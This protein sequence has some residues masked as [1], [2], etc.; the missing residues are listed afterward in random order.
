MVLLLFS[1]VWDMR[2]Q[3]CIQ[4]L[5]DR[6][7]YKPENTIGV[8]AYDAARRQLVT[9]SSC[10]RAWA[11]TDSAASHGIGHVHP[12]SA[13]LYNSMFTEVSKEG[14]TPL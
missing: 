2:N 4:T 1:Q 5:V 8:M 9:G 6:E 13:V 12:V 11:L 14:S 7:V 10:L 3:R